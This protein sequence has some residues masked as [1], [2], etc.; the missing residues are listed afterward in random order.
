M[1]SFDK[2][3]IKGNPSSILAPRILSLVPD[4]SLFLRAG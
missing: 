2:V 1:D 3:L 4:F